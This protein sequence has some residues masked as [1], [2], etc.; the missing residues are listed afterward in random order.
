MARD[1]RRLVDLGVPHVQ[2]VGAAPLDEAPFDGRLEPIWFVGTDGS[3]WSLAVP[4]SSQCQQVPSP[5]DLT[6]VAVSPDGSIWCA[7]VRGALW[8]MHGGTWSAVNVFT[9]KV[10]DVAVA[11][12]RTMYL[13]MANGRYYSILPGGA[14]FYHGVLL[15]IEAIAG[16]GRPSDT[17]PYGQ[18][19]GVSPTFGS[20]AL[21][22]CGTVNGWSPTNIRDV[23]DLS[24]AE[25]GTLWLVKTDGTIWITRDGGTTQLRVG[26]EG[27]TRIAGGVS[28]LAWAV[29]LN[30]GA[31]VYQDVGDAVEPPP[32]P[33]PPPAP[34]PP[35]PPVGSAPTIGVSATGGG[36][37]TIFKVTGSG[38][39]PN[40]QVTIRGARIDEGQVH[41]FYWAAMS[42]GGG[43]LSFDIP[44]PCVPGLVISFSANDG[45]QNPADLT[46]RL[47]SNTVQASCPPG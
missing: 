7:D 37:E 30:G 44:L 24:L 32:P 21:C 5:G 35:P 20:G 34:S 38:F 36:A 27:A 31:W 8:V 23:V 2:D 11:A 9:E 33:P 1:W 15:N 45:R 41:Q 3:L 28:G 12:D 17:D 26:G 18:A 46:D 43:N 13:V 16:I 19:W 40:V 22:H 4:F 6:R 29:S 39:V 25:D 14:P 42:D 10:K 47:W